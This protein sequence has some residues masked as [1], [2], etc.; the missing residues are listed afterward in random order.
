[1]KK[2]YLFLII[3]ILLNSCIKKNEIIIN[4]FNKSLTMEYTIDSNH[5]YTEYV[6]KLKGVVNDTILINKKHYFCGKIDTIIR[7]DF[8]G[9]DKYIQLNFEPFRAKKGILKIVQYAN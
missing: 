2:I 3:S 6:F 5:Q 8:Y 4:D 9:G 7:N 1:M